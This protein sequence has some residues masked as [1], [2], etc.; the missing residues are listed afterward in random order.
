M[1]TASSALCSLCSL[2]AIEFP[3]HPCHPVPSG[4][5]N[6]TPKT[7]NRILAC[8]GFCDGSTD[9]NHSVKPR[10]PDGCDGCDGFQRGVPIH[11]PQLD[12][13]TGHGTLK[14]GPK[15]TALASISPRFYRG[16]NDLTAPREE[17]LSPLLGERARVRA[18]LSTYP[19]IQRINKSLTY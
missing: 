13:N 4:S 11:M 8:D 2:V 6:R 14:T 5:K 12:L 17:G 7:D 15:L 18:S 9:Q 19:P 10:F 3:P 16:P 1:C